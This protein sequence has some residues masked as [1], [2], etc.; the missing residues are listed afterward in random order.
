MKTSIKLFLKIL[1]LFAFSIACEKDITNPF[2]PDCPKEIWTPKNFQVVQAENK[3][4]LTWQQ[5]NLNIT[6]FKIERKVGTM[7]WSNVASPGKTTT[8]WSDS[9]LKG[10]EVHQYR[11]YAYAGDNI[12]N[13]VTGNLT[14]ILK[15]NVVALAA[16]NIQVFTA[17]LNGSVNANGS[18]TTVTFLYK[19]K[20]SS[21]WISVDANNKT[22]DGKTVVS[23]SANISNLS[24]GEEYNF[25]LKA[26]NSSGEALSTE[27]TFK[28]PDFDVSP[29]SN[30]VSWQAGSAIFTVNSG[31]EWN[32]AKDASWLTVFK[33][34]NTTITANYTE[35][36]ES[37]P[38][39]GNITV[40]GTGGIEKKVSVVQAAKP[41][42][43]ISPENREV[44]YQAGT[45]NFTVNSNIDW[46]VT[47]DASWLTVTKTNNTTI[48]I[49]YT[50]NTTNNSRTANIKVSGGGLEKTVTVNQGV[51]AP[52]EL[53]IS[54]VSREV[55]PVAGTTTFSVASNVDWSV[56]SVSASWVK[57]TK[58]NNTT[59]SISYEANAGNVSRSASITIS[60]GGIEKT[61]TVIQAGIILTVTPTSREVTPVAGTTSFTVNSNVTWSIKNVS[62]T[63]LTATK[64]NNTTINVSFN[65]NTTTNSRSATITLTAGAVEKTVTVTQNKPVPVVLQV[66]PNS[67]EVGPESGTTSFTVNSNV[68]WIP[69]ESSTWLTAT[70]TN[71]TTISV[72]FMANTST[73]S[74]SASIKVSGGGIEK[75]VSVIQQ[76]PTLV[77]NPSSIILPWQG[78][79][80]SITVNSNV[81]WNFTK[82]ASWLNVSKTNNTTLSISCV[83]NSTVNSKTASI[84]VSGGGLVRNITVTQPGICDIDPDS[85]RVSWKAGSTNFSVNTG[86]G[87]SLTDNA[88]WLTATKTSGSNISVEYQRNESTNSRTAII[89]ASF[90]GNIKETATVIQNGFF[91][92]QPNGISVSG[93]AGYTTFKVT[94]GVDWNA[95]VKDSW[96]KVTII[97]KTT[98][99]VNYDSYYNIFVSRYANIRVYN[100]DGEEKIVSLKQSYW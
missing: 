24:P 70:K 21:D 72:N 93:S 14:P 26:V 85:R 65:E 48:S 16:S 83:A 69:S 76:E 42:L 46:N 41:T 12:S 91:D 37:N 27:Q 39:T 80:S 61:V 45:T 52:P 40:T 19:K 43:E 68:E 10:G 28:T 67:R 7:D 79:S 49:T 50:E 9:D 94:S 60:G 51:K 71:S 18:L 53:V 54:P 99:R 47:K 35:N 5:D 100:V 30:E 25:K 4:D 63:W 74:R 38:R 96:L 62:A 17:T 33:T 59:I 89:T 13:T 56:K 31:V 87:W 58:T 15:A 81:N 44:T 66:T 90:T 78:G 20:S 8:S 2:D 55:N 22:V 3:L 34:N 98:L 57:A 6:G 11:L 97:D 75:T 23:V 73:N 84:N 95:S 92:V 86:V 29:S 77:V 36:T 82:D 32:V 64:A 1:F 88:T